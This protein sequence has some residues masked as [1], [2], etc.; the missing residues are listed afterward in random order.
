MVADSPASTSL[1]LPVEPPPESPA[2]ETLLTQRVVPLR[3]P[4]RWIATVVVLAL[5]AQFVHGLISNPFYEWDRFR[6]WFLRPVVLDGLVITLKV[7]A[8]SAVLG[9]LGGV[10]LALMRVSRN[11]LLRAVSWGYIW[12]F[13]SVPLIVLLLVIYNFS[14]IYPKLSLGV[15]FGPGFAGFET[16]DLL[17]YTV[18]GVIALSLNEA[19][20]AAEVVRAGIQSV[21]QGQHEAADALG[22]GRG[23]QF[24]RIILPQALRAIVPAYVNQLIGLIKAS[25]L[26]FY[27]SLLDLFGVVMSMGSTYPTDIIPLLLVATAWYVVLTSLLSVVQYYVERYYA[28]GAL[29]TMPPTPFQQLRASFARRFR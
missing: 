11:P 2:R 13:R 29:R 27:V 4:W 25:S 6:Y 9:F 24:R 18:I 20:Y 1:D 16:T 12:L 3:H 23:R 7:T 8:W 28:R 22:L 17:G 15:P 5:L 26:V 10:V 19:A 21:D 14:A